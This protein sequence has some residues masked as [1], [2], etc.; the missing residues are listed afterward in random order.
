MPSG[1]ESTSN[2]EVFSALVEMATSADDMQS[3]YQVEMLRMDWQCL[4]TESLR[5][6]AQ[7]VTI[8]PSIEPELQMMIHGPAYKILVSR[9]QTTVVMSQVVR[10][11]LVGRP[12]QL[13][14]QPT[15]AQQSTGQKYQKRWPSSGQQPLQSQQAT[16]QQQ[17]SFQQ[18]S[19]RQQPPGQPHL[20]E[21]EAEGQQYSG[22]QQSYRQSPS[23]G[24]QS[25]GQ[26]A[27]Y[28]QPQ[29]YGQQADYP[30]Q[31][32]YVQPS[33]YYESPNTPQTA[34][35]PSYSSEMEP[36]NI[37]TMMGN[38]RLDE[39]SFAP[40]NDSEQHAYD[41]EDTEQPI[42]EEARSTSHRIHRR[43]KRSSRR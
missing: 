13:A 38:M 11:P 35:P 39:E 31:P 23:Y 5:A 25:D 30:Q 29:L 20:Y 8:A 9:W 24:Q 10:H 26:Q 36:R 16:Y 15:Y 7:R 27:A 4:N 41:D 34:S 37:S 12:A 6:I 2:G 17:P 42:A 33:Y 28:L 18:I 22:Q 43:S 19:Y 1:Y 3:G 14:R 40:P 21:E 32:S